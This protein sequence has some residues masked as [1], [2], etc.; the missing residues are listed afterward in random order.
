MQ[1]PFS[2]ARITSRRNFRKRRLN[3][4][5]DATIHTLRRCA[6][7]VLVCALWY[8]RTQGIYYVKYVRALHSRTVLKSNSTTCT[9]TVKKAKYCLI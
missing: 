2:P 7:R 9:F 3:V 6:F 4:D 8:L 5:A 1:K